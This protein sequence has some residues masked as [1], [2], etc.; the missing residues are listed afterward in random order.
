MKK[1][2]I[3]IMLFILLVLCTACDG[4][5]TR[6]I[7]HAGFEVEDKSFVCDN[8]YPKN[9]DD[10]TYEKVKYFT[11]TNMITETGR[12]YEVS[13]SQKYSNNENCKIADTPIIVKAIMD[14]TIVKAT[15]N[16]YYYL[17]GKNSSENYKE[18]TNANNSYNLYDMLLKGDDVVKVVSANSNGV[19]YVLKTDGNV[20]A[21]TI[22]SRSKELKLVSTQVAYDKASFGGADIIDFNYVD[23]KLGTYVKTRNKVYRMKQT[24]HDECTKYA[25]IECNYIMEED[26]IFEK[27]NDRILI[28]NGMTLIT[29]YKKVFTATN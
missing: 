4:T 15:D 28:F 6:D 2:S 20:Y 29:D 13:L 14:D 1:K 27:Y 16:K 7:R 26:S 3:T 25:D 19:Y 21:I 11:D 5:V 10:T 18:I 23:G 17:A 9:K 8:V 24:N 12:V 22:D